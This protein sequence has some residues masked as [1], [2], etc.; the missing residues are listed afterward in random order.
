MTSDEDLLDCPANYDLG[1]TAYAHWKL[2]FHSSI[3]YASFLDALNDLLWADPSES[4]N[5]LGLGWNN[6]LMVDM[7]EEIF[8]VEMEA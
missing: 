3:M 5:Y 6:T 2:L 4:N 1:N 7:A 8:T